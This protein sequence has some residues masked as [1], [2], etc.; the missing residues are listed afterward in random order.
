MRGRRRNQARV[1]QYGR[2]HLRGFGRGVLHHRRVK[3]IKEHPRAG[4][5]GFKL[6]CV[7][8]TKGVADVGDVF[9]TVGGEVQ[10]RAIIPEMP[11]QG[12]QFRQC[13]MVM[14]VGTDVPKQGLK[15]RQH[16]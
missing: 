5:E 3:R 2:H 1:L 9:A 4:V 8:C 11:R 10:N 6:S 13:H 15:H 14:N 12:V 7:L 16:G